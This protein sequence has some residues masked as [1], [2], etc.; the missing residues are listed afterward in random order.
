MVRSI[1]AVI[2]GIVTWM[3]VA[4]LINYL[5]RALLPGYVAAEPTMSF[6]LAMMFARLALAVV[7][8]IIAGFF[9]ALVARGNMIPVYICAALLVLCFLPVHYNVWSKFPL[10][11]H[12]FFLITLAPLVLLGALIQRRGGRSATWVS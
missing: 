1:L 5:I 3:I 10:W 12:A 11:Y 6:T 9:T 4:T 2:T 7:T 8:S